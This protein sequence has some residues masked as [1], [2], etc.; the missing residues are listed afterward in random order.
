MLRFLPVEEPIRFFTLA[1]LDHIMNELKIFRSCTLVLLALGTAGTGWATVAACAITA[2][3]NS[4][5]S[6]GT[7]SATTGCFQDDLSYTSLSLTGGGKTGAGVAPTAGSIDL[8]STG[9][10]A[11][12]STI[13]PVNLFVDGF[14]SIAGTGTETATV[15][16]QATANTGVG[17]GGITYTPPASAGQYWGYTTLTLAPSVASVQAGD[18]VTITESFCLN[19]TQATAGG[20][21]AAADQGTITAKY[22]GSAA[23]AFTCLFG[24]AGICLSAT[25]GEV[26][27][28]NLSF[29]PTTIATSNVVAING[30]AATTVTL[31]NFEDSFGEQS[32]TPEPASFGLMGAALAS[33]AVCGYRRRKQQF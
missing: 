32:F 22:T 15:A 8:Y 2:P 12:G 18:T 33:L 3:G 28:A 19:A 4:L 13:G 9:T 23:V 14:A 21:C 30:A 29:A 11:S 7:G 16:I 31:T 24:T 1:S 6:I 10:A 26:S 5:T 27:F 17:V 25:S 20:N